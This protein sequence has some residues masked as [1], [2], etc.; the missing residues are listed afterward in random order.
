MSGKGGGM[1][2]YPQEVIDTLRNVIE[3]QKIGSVED[4]DKIIKLNT[5]LGIAIGTLKALLWY[6]I[7]D[8]AKSAINRILAEL[9]K[10]K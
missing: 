8:D 7:S 10:G 6:N 1:S 5:Q 3:A 2:D 4:W 9:D